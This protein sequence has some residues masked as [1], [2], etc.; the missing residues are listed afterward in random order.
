MS[1]TNTDIIKQNTRQYIYSL[2]LLMF[3]PLSLHARIISWHEIFT[4]TGPWQGHLEMLSINKGGYFI[5]Q[6]KVNHGQ[7][8]AFTLPMA[9]STTYGISIIDDKEDIELS[10]MLILNTMEGKYCRFHV[11]IHKNNLSEVLNVAAHKGSSCGYIKTKA[12]K[13]SFEV[14]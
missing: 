6:K 7:R 12:N 9:W 2:I 3:L 11:A 14:K 4:N 1:H 10:Y 8:Y 5:D 13:L